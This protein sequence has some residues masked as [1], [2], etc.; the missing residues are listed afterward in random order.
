MNRDAHEIAG[1]F[2]GVVGTVI[3]S[4]PYENQNIFHQVVGSYIGG[5]LGALLPDLIDPPTNPNHRSLGHGFI[6]TTIC[7]ALLSKKISPKWELYWLQQAESFR[8][9]HQSSTNPFQKFVNWCLIHI[10]HTLVWV[11]KGMIWGYTSHLAL[12][13]VTPK[14]LPAVL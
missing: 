1:K 7:L 2:L 11:C 12:D 9:L 13:S 6:P 14:G 10:C 4:D 8:Q 5:K 3:S